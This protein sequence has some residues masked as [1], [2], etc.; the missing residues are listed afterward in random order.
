MAHLGDSTIIGLPLLRAPCFDIIRS[1]L[2]E[3]NAFLSSIWSPRENMLAGLA[4]SLYLPLAGGLNYL[5]NR[6]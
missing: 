5:V 3:A 6:Q 4:A 1:I 2:L